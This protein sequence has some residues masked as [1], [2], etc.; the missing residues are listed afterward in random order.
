MDSYRLILRY[1]TQTYL[2]EKH[3][4]LPNTVTE[5]QDNLSLVPLFLYTFFCLIFFSFLYLLVF[6]MPFETFYLWD[7]TYIRLIKKKKNTNLKNKVI[8]D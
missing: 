5:K 2:L 3:C 7:Y 4:I 1:L 6:C 8:W